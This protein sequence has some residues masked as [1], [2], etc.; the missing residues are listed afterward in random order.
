MVFAPLAFATYFT[1]GSTSNRVGKV[2]FV[3]SVIWKATIKI[4]TCLSILLSIL[5]VR[6]PSPIGP[7][8]DSPYSQPYWVYYNR[9]YSKACLAYYSHDNDVEDCD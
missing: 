8:Y 2:A 3:A 4:G 9:P 5:V 6:I 1:A 7:Y